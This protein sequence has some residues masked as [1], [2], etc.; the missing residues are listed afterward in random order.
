M[1]LLYL[2][3]TNE[4][5]FEDPF[6][7]LLSIATAIQSFM[8]FQE[9]ISNS[10]YSHQDASPGTPYIIMGQQNAC[11]VWSSWR[12]GCQIYTCKVHFPAF[13]I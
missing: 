2:N 1:Y 7:L 3:G 10:H 5:S 11:R 6:V 12:A 8:E 4:G 13:P 9:S